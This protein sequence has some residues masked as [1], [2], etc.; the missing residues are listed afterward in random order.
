MNKYIIFTTLL[1]IHFF[2]Y[3]MYKE[4]AHIK[5]YIPNPTC[6][7][8]GY[9][10]EKI[11]VGSS[12]SI[13][14]VFSCIT[15][16][17]GSE[18]KEYITPYIEVFVTQTPMY[19]ASKG[20]FFVGQYDVCHVDTPNIIHV[21]GTE[22]QVHTNPGRQLLPIT[23]SCVTN[24]Q[25][26]YDNPLI[27]AGSKID[28]S[29][30]IWDLTRNRQTR[31]LKN[32]TNTPIQHLAALSYTKMLAAR[33]DGVLDVM[34]FDGNTYTYG[35]HHN[36]PICLLK[37]P[38]EGALRGT[39][40]DVYS[41]TEAGN[42]FHYDIRKIKPNIILTSKMPIYDLLINDSSL[43]VATDNGTI[44]LYDLRNTDKE[45]E[46]LKSVDTTPIIKLVKK[47]VIDIVALSEAGTVSF[48]SK[49]SYP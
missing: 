21:S 15:S 3:A 13:S 4:C 38:S 27:C 31:L 43:F 18:G 49:Q 45:Q 19:Y 9:L 7:A 2:S 28:G 24:I 8:S 30:C 41:G 22:C 6:L 1:C 5:T 40:G 16:K 32:H 37:G 47:F 33:S 42:I 29:V 36:D 46:I 34:D 10:N 25:N 17:W 48:W 26:Y 12:D 23:I 44:K 11:A 20:L 39:I 14:Q 35:I